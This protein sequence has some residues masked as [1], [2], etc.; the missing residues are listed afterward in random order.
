VLQDG[1][2]LD[3]NEFRQHPANQTDSLGF[4]H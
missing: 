2:S 3:Y 1:I 4:V